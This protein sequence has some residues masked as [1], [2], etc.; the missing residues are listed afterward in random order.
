[1]PDLEALGWRTELAA[2][3]AEHAVAGRVPGRVALEHNHVFRVLTEAGEV[4]AE[5]SGRVRHR[6]TERRELPTVG[7][8]VAVKPDP[9]GGRAIIAALLPRATSFTRKAPGR[10]TE[11]QVIAANIDTVFLVFGLDAGLNAR[12]IERYVL[13][14]RQSGAAPVVVLNKVDL[15]DDEDDPAA[16]RVAVMAEAVSAAGEAP[17]RLLTTRD[18][19]ARHELAPWLVPGRTV[20]VLGPSGAGKSSLINTLIGENRLAT[21]EV[22]ET[23]A[24]GRHT[25]VHRELVVLASGGIL[26][27][28]PGIRELQLW[29]A[30]AGMA[31]AFEDIAAIGAECRFRDCRHDQEPGCA[32]KAAV[33]S[34]RLDAGRY[35][36]FL[37]LQ[38]ERETLARRLDERAILDNKR[39][40][41]VANKA[42]KALQKPRGR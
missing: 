41:R 39:Q 24:R 1:V 17:V 28:T 42:L 5:T 35:L 33:E 2:A 13:V 19:S 12:A 25:S 18:A 9:A 36:S 30:D 6:A 3:F 23:D 40:S 8:W 37:K 10:E 20:A 21:G 34:G 7:D 11:A 29:D 31:D 38:E 4:L 26:I 32:V 22:R 14:A 16:V 15:L 27:D